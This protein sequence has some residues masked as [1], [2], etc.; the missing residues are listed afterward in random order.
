MTYTDRWLKLF[1]KALRA[2]TPARFEVFKF[3]V[4][5]SGTDE[6]RYHKG[7]AVWDMIHPTV[8]EASVD[9]HIGGKL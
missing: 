3:G 9:V 8:A 2:F 7:I 4:G 6:E 5:F 1:E